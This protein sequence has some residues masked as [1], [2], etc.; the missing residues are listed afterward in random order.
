MKLVIV[1]AG[2]V[3]YYLIRELTHEHEIIIVE[4]NE[5]AANKI[6]NQ[7][8]A[9]VVQ[10]DGTILTVL[11][12]VCKDADMLIALTG[13]DENNLIACQ[14]AKKLLHVPTTM[15]RVNNPKNLEVMEKFGVDKSFSGT[16]VIA[17]MIEQEIDYQGLQIIR[18]V[19]N[20]NHVLIEFDLSPESKAVG[21]SLAQYSFVKGSRV[22]VITY[23][24]GRVVAPEGSTVMHAGD[25]LMMVCPKNSIEE[26][27]KAMVQV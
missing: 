23:T 14:I 15:A 22:V 25:R 3:A 9:E 13:K 19:K 4:Q 24:D 10:G 2:K 6:S 18:Q 21:K 7:L 27:W 8:T 12:P 11:E 20:S 1:G 5:E 16:K 17:Q 26:I